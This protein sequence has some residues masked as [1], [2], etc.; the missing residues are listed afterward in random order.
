MSIPTACMRLDASP[1]QPVCKTAVPE[2]NA[3]QAARLLTLGR[4]DLADSSFNDIDLIPF[5]TACYAM[6]LPVDTKFVSLL[7]TLI[8]C[9]WAKQKLFLVNVDLAF[10]DPFRVLSSGKTKHRS[11]P[12]Q[13]STAA[14]L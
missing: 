4:L 13:H 11:I 3:R 8:L 12:P 1:R 2:S 10:S 14:F 5:G 6:T 7:A 9:L